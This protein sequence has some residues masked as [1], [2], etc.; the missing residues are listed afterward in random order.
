MAGPEAKLE[1]RLVDKV[2]QNGGRAYKF[3]SPS[4]RSV[5]DRICVLPGGKV[6]FVEMKA[7]GKKPTPKQA[8]EIERLRKLGA[9]V[10]VIDSKESV[11][12]FI[13]EFVDRFF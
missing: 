11:D 3:T 5:P 2:R 8:M 1:R 7:P 6:I 4:Q 12:A 9:E 10:E 13:D